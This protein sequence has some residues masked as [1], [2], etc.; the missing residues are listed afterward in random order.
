MSGLFNNL[1]KISAAGLLNFALGG[2]GLHI[3]D[4]Y[5]QDNAVATTFGDSGKA[6]KS[7]IT[8][9]GV[10]GQ[11]NGSMTPDHINDHITLSQ[12]GLYIALIFMSVSTSEGGSDDYGFSLWKN[13]GATEF[14]NVHTHRQFSGGGG[15]RGS[16]GLG[17]VIAGTAGDTIEPWAWN[18]NNTESLVIDDITLILLQAAR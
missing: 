8:I 9:F 15:D 16:I 2:G 14:P 12:T 13:N 18:E 10:D 11:S 4:M 1:L 5:V 7:Q 6:N 3:C 17:G